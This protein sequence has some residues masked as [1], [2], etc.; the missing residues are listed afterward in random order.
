[1][2]QQV[3]VSGDQVIRLAD[4]A[5]VSSKSAP[6]SWHTAT[7]TSC[8]CVGFSFRGR[9]RHVAAVAELERI[10]AAPP[11]PTATPTLTYAARR[12]AARAHSA[13]LFD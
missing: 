7:A 10:A 4:V 3:E 2:V 1:M 12:A 13:D 11:A 6:G 8:D 5:L 9:C